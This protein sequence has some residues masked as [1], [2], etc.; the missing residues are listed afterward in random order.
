MRKNILPGI[1]TAW[2]GDLLQ[3]GGKGG[4]EPERARVTIKHKERRK[5]NFFLLRWK[6]EHIWGRLLSLPRVGKG[7]N[8]SARPFGEGKRSCNEG[9][10]SGITL[11][12]PI[13]KRKAYFYRYRGK[14]K[15]RPGRKVHSTDV[16]TSSW[17]R[18]KKKREEG[19]SNFPRKGKGEGTLEP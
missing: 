13:K 10:A 5:W 15:K 16:Q 11:L 6:R 17:T 3:G 8:L 14:E 4:A 12:R 18:K 19:I 2:G 1:F 9:E 7:E